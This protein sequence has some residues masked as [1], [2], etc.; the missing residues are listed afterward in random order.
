MND[1]S[2]D[3]K[4]LAV[5]YCAMQAEL[6]TAEKN[7]TGGRGKYADIV[8]VIE[9]SRP[10]LAKHGLSVMQQITSDEHGN[11]WLVTI[12]MHKNGERI[13]STM[14]LRPDKNIMID[15]NGKETPYNHALAGCITY[16]RRYA[17]MAIIGMVAENEDHDGEAYAPR[18]NKTEEP[19]YITNTQLGELQ[20]AITKAKAVNPDI[21]A[22]IKNG[23][24]ITHLMDIPADKYQATLD[25][26]RSI[27]PKP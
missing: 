5:A 6:P 15:K 22:Q 27:I 14:L 17:Y 26:V 4:E 24:K 19:L 7:S 11:H 25:K 20:S 21:E 10:I 3:I 2:E 9:V 12:L 8:E 16:F 23:F 1:N 13:S 18:N